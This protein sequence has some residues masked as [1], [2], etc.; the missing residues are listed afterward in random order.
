MSGI[1]T[2]SIIGKDAFMQ[3]IAS[4]LGRPAPLLEPPPRTVAGVP[5][6]YAQIGLSEQERIEQF[7]ANWT[8]LTGTV[9]IVPESE[10]AQQVPALVRQVCA[11]RG[12]G[13]AV[14]W[15]RPEL[16]GWPLDA[17]L[18]EAG[19][20]VLRWRE[21]GAAED[22]GAEEGAA[23]AAL[24][25]DRDQAPNGWNRRSPLLRSAEQCRLGIVWADYAVANTGTLV[26]LAQGGQGRSVSLL[27]DALFAVFRADRLAARMGEVFE[28]IR[29]RYPDSAS[30]PSSINFVT[31]PSRSSDIENDL[32]VGI[33]GPGSVYAVILAAT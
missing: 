33:H 9:W 12:I 7:C 26:L 30:I 16:D 14:R 11:E 18:G 8:A 22:S 24:T 10:A 31:G 23:G 28:A 20:T 5:E 32:T 6:H 1:K 27:P 2:G 29:S 25:G 15:D 13:R 17:V 19:V 21:D 4:R 3:R